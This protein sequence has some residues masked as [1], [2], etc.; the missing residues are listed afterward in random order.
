MRRADVAMYVAKGR[1]SR[2]EVHDPEL[3]KAN[4]SRLDT[5]RDLDAALTDNQ[6]VLHYQPKIAVQTGTMVGVEALVR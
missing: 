3:D 6:F 1:R 5:V 4:R 2:V